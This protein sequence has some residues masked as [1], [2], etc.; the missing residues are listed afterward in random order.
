MKLADQRKIAKMLSVKDKEAMAR[1]YN[2]R[3][4]GKGFMDVI[5]KIGGFI[6]PLVKE[7]G[8]TVLKEIILPLVKK[9]LGGNGLNLGGNGLQLAGKRTAGRGKKGCTGCKRRSTLTLA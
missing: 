9:K 1:H 8:P 4:G 2:P 7:L 3:M 5:K 6:S